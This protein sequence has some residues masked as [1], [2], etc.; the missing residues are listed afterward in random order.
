MKNLTL[1]GKRVR[2]TAGE[3]ED[4]RSLKQNR[5]WWG[6]ILKEISEQATIN[7]VR[8]AAEA[9]HELAKRQFLGFKI[10]KVKVAGK[11]KPVVIRR[12]RSTKDCTVKQFN[13]LI[14]QMQAFAVTDLHV[15]FSTDWYE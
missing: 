10:E 13:V 7:G 11:R 8:Y 4:D 6:V 2:I 1:Q 12:L 9:W 14:E 15:E 3:D 5:Y